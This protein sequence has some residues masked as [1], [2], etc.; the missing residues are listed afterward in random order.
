MPTKNK[1][2]RLTRAYSIVSLIGILIVAFIMAYFYRSV[3]VSALMESQSENNVALTRALANSVWDDYGG[4]IASASSLS[5]S[6][7]HHHPALANLRDVFA[8]KMDGLRVLKINIFDRS[9][10]TIFST[11]AAQIGESRSSY[12]GFIA[13]LNGDVV[14]DI[15]FK[16]EFKTF[17][18][19]MKDRYLVYSYIPIRHGAGQPVVA[20]FELYTDITDVMGDIKITEYKII[21]LV[22]SLMLILYIFLLYFVRRADNTIKNYEKENFETQQERFQFLALH[23][24]LTG[25]PKRRLLVDLLEQTIQRTQ[26]RNQPLMVLHLDIDRL[27]LINDKLGYEAGNQVILE[28]INRASMVTSDHSIRGRVGGDELVFVIE[29]IPYIDTDPLASRLISQVSKP[30]VINDAEVTLTISLGIALYIDDSYDA[31]HLLKDAEAAM[32]RAKELG[33]NRYAYYTEELNIRA[34]ERFDLEHGLRTALANNEFEVFYQA[35]INTRSGR[36][37]GAEALLRWRRSGGD[38]VFPDVFIPALEDMGLII[39]VGAWVLR[40]AC[41]QCKTWHEQGYADMHVSVNISMRQFQSDSLISD[42]QSALTESGLAAEYL[43]LELTESLLASDANRTIHLLHELKKMGLYLSI[44][45]FG[46]GYSSLSY[47]MHFPVDCLKIDRAFVRDATI[48]NDHANL[49]RMI[50]SMAK[51]LHLKTVAEGIETDEHRVFLSELECD[52]MQGYFFSKPIPSNQ[53]RQYL[54]AQ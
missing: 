6:E 37:A 31:A 40:S 51:N 10:L 30:F 25:L 42:I 54:E 2:F 39:P 26:A 43:E 45:D 35:K 11:E 29:S 38:I 28:V 52:E 17:D 36:V 48:N 18:V 44:D 13:A 16:K 1:T 21:A 20:V 8:Q 19:V 32:L 53:F 24:N 41:Q 47:L 46:T 34:V 12:P 50:V 15:A 23:D 7:L 14:S 27:K 49:T 22:S 4:F 9:G 3:A 33:R 5:E